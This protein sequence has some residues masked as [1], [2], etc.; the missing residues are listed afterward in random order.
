M[1]PTLK[2]LQ[3]SI[4]MLSSDPSVKKVKV[5][6]DLFNLIRALFDR[7]VIYRVAH[8]VDTAH[9]FRGIDIEIDHDKEGFDYEII[10]KEIDN[11]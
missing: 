1:T 7:E 5:S 4:R 8:S 2:D 3:D 6:R 9:I 11:V 10:Y